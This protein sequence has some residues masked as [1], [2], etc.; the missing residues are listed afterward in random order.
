MNTQRLKLTSFVAA[1]LMGSALSAQALTFSIPFMLGHVVAPTTGGVLGSSPVTVEV[2]PFS[3]Q[4]LAPWAV[5][6]RSS[7]PAFFSSYTLTALSGM[8]IDNAYTVTPGVDTTLSFWTTGYLGA[9][10]DFSTTPG[11]TWAPDGSINGIIA[12][13][14]HGGLALGGQSGTDSALYG[15]FA[16]VANHTYQFMIG[17]WAGHN[18]AGG[19]GTLYIDYHIIPEPSTYALALGGGALGVSLC[20]RRRHKAVA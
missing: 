3:A 7:N 4:K 5:G 14:D 18:P 17:Q 11:L 2:S 15:P 10:I 19:S 12:N 6:T 13:D 1:A 16:L 8:V 9:P 20:M